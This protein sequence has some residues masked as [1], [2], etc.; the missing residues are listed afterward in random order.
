MKSQSSIFNKQVSTVCFCKM[1]LQKEP[2]HNDGVI[3]AR[4]I[5]CKFLSSERKRINEPFE[6]LK[7]AKYCCH[8]GCGTS[9]CQLLTLPTY[10]KTIFCIIKVN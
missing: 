10:R 8:F 6:L 7:V 9:F 3:T 1:Q 4:C 2:S 5:L